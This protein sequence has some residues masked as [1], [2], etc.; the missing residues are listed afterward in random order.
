M[1]KIM[2]VVFVFLLQVVTVF[3]EVKL[4]P[5]FAS[6]MVLQQEKDITVWGVAD[7]GEKINIEF[8]GQAAEGKADENGKWKLVL[9]PVK[10]GGP[11]TMK[12][13]DRTLEDV[14]VGEVWLASGQS[15]MTFALVNS[16]N[17]KE[18]AAKADF[19]EIRF[20]QAEQNASFVPREVCKGNWEKCAPQKAGRFSAVAYYYAKEIHRELKVPVGIISAGYAGSQCQNW[21]DRKTLLNDPLLTEFNYEEGPDNEA[22]LNYTAE[23]I[24]KKPEFAKWYKNV[25][26][27][28][29]AKDNLP[30]L[31]K[32]SGDPK[33]TMEDRLPSGYYNAMIYPVRN[34]TI[35][36]VIW[37]QGEGNCGD[38]LYRNLFE[39]MINSWRKIF[40]QGDFPFLFVQ[41]ANMGNKA[42]SP[43][44][45]CRG[46]VRNE[47][48]YILKLKNTAM[49]VTIDIGDADNVHAKNKKDVGSRLSL[50]AL[51]TVY[52]KN[53]DKPVTVRYAMESNPDCNL[54]NKEGLPASPFSTAS[55]D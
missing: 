1:K 43:E 16:L 14:L 20:F 42:V 52:G 24:K 21:V 8:N 50:A 48:R 25:E 5:I 23:V 28:V 22:V 39:A 44:F 4:P 18:E 7:P 10:A 33:A 34:Y 53:I 37:Y 6:R 49:A 15:N 12:I 13:N 36:G 29:K 26:A 3:S 27:A 31:P 54:Y 2:V 51:G 17:G 41:I 47:Q 46:D 40:A 35:K 45:G 11:F 19:P 9:K 32:F 38:T 30:A 55:L